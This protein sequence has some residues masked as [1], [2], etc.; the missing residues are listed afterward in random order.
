MDYMLVIKRD[1]T[2]VL[3]VKVLP[4]KACVTQHKLMICQMKINDVVQKVNTRY[5]SK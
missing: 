5:V 4:N 2:K 3:D 1:R